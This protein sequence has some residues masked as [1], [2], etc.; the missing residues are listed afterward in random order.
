M[1]T[2]RDRREAM[3]E[4]VERLASLGVVTVTLIDD[5]ERDLLVQRRRYERR[6]SL[7]N[8]V[9]HEYVSSTHWGVSSTHWGGDFLEAVY[10]D[11][12]EPRVSWS[13]GGACEDA[14]VQVMAE[15]YQTAWAD[16]ARQAEDH[17]ELA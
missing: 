4:N 8:E 5:P 10:E 9:K 6:N 1:T 14:G 11:E 17:R 13:S 15:V 16:L 2:M 7:R 3:L 12:P